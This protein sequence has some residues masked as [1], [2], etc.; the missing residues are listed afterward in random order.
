MRAATFLALALGAVLLLGSIGLGVRDRS[1]KRTA[2]NHV[3]TNKVDDEASHVEEYF[4][5]ARSIN[6]ITAHNPS[7][8]DF[9]SK[10]GA[11]AAKVKAHGPSIRGAEAALDYLER[12]YPARIGEACFIDRSGAEN[13][14]YV[15]GV[16]AEFKD[17]SL[18]ENENPFFA[19]TFALPVGQVYQAKPYVSPDTKEWVIS[20]STPVPASGYPAAA[21]VHFEVTIES[22]RRRA[23]ENAGKYEV[24]IV[25]AETGMVVIDSRFRQRPG[26]RLGRRDD[27]RF[28]TLLR[29]DSL[30]GSTTVAGHRSAFRRL[31]RTPNNENDWYV[32]AVNPQPTGSLLSDIGWAPAGMA[33]AALALLLLAAISFRSSRRTLDEAANTDALTGLSNRRKLMTDLEAACDGTA[34]SDRFAL[35]LYDLDGFKS[36]NDSFGHLPGDAL[37]QRLGRKLAEATTNWGTAYRLGGDEFCVLSPLRVGEEAVG[38]STVGARA[39]SEAGK[40]FSITASHGSVVFPDETRKPS[41]LLASADLRM[42]ANKNKGRPSAA[43]QTTD[44]LVR[45]QRERSSLLGPHASEVAELAAA[46]GQ[47]LGLADQA[48][49]LLQ[50]AAELHDIGKVAIPDAVLDKEGD[51]TENEWRLIREHTVVGE[52]M[53]SAAPAL[54]EV[55]TIVRASHE[56]FDG[57]GYPDQLAGDAIPLEASII[58]AADAFHAMTSDRPYHRGRTP[59]QAITEIERCSGTQ[60]HPRVAEALVMVVSERERTA[61]PETL[62]RHGLKRAS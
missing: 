32:V 61:P 52:R 43:R 19:P 13:A 26:S 25:D 31:Q 45:V 38:I 15:R 20:N 37:L 56:R 53:L 55:A 36:Y 16:R 2:V 23:A 5:R 59:E 17:L 9:Y 49:H 30:A 28:A 12:L 44:V 1:E 41:E 62:P 51:L 8:R 27:R 29:E 10:P 14:R 46:I 33:A 35:V 48:L 42:Y 50:Q 34:Q 18:N 60:F 47:R 57:H 58:S 39:L 21:I 4:E 11:R 54:H 6:L 24:V 3:L 22:F 40:G 7:F